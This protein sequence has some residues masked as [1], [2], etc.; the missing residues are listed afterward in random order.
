MAQALFILTCFLGIVF[1]YFSAKNINNHERL[2]VSVVTIFLATLFGS[3]FLTRI[4]QFGLLLLSSILVI[5]IAIVALKSRFAYHNQNKNNN[6]NFILYAI[7]L[8]IFVF[9]AIYPTYYLLGGRDPGLYFIYSVHIANTGGLNLD[10]P[11]LRELYQNFGDAI[12]LGYPGIYSGFNRGLSEDPANLIPQ[13]MHLFPAFGAIAHKIAGIEGVVRANAVI[14]IIALWSFFTVTRRLTGFYTALIA[15]LALGLNAAFIW[16]ARITL[17]ET[18]SIALLFSGIY[19]LIVSYDRNSTNWAMLGG[20][21][22]GLSVLNRLDASLNVLLI[23]G[24]LLLSAYNHKHFKTIALPATISYLIGSSIG[25]LDGLI[26]TFPYMHDLWRGGSLSKLVYLNYFLPLIGISIYLTSKLSFLSHERRKIL[27]FLGLKFAVFSLIVWSVFAFFIWH[28]IQEGFNARSINELAWYTTP[29][30]FI[31][32]IY[33]IRI[34][35]NDTESSHIILPLIVT[36]LATFI[37][38]TWKP[39]ITPDHIWA[40][41]RWVTHAIPFIILFS[42]IGLKHIFTSKIKTPIKYSIITIVCVFYLF[43]SLWMS[44]PFVFKSIYKQSSYDYKHLSADLNN[45]YAS[46]FTR[47]GQLA[48]ILTYIYGHKTILLTNAGLEI[49]HSGQFEN[50][51]FIGVD[52]FMPGEHLGSHS[53]C[54]NYLEKLRGARPRQLYRRCYNANIGIVQDDLKTSIRAYPTNPRFGSR[55]GSFDS[56]TQS[57]SST[58]KR[59]FLLFGP[60]IKLNPGK[61]KVTWLVHSTE[62]TKN[63]IGFVDIVSNKGSNVITRQDISNLSLKADSSVE[64][65]FLLTDAVDDLEFRFYVFD[66]IDLTISQVVLESIEE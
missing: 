19:F 53:I 18:L 51:P 62:E 27:F 61:Y 33:G 44:K 38:F 55:V 64:I 59:G 46:Y 37:L 48:S 16:N 65:E 47:N 6:K 9:Y 63:T 34:A 52:P 58:G 31:S 28:D 39:T 2:F 20:A 30:L 54:G 40:S 35:K 60:Y 12:R 43:N 3:L 7:L 50:I 56:K 22:L 8:S 36:G 1:F 21:I 57:V 4:G 45:S 49:M 32:F 29:V 5:L 25:F 10:L 42:A 23:F 17:T 14:A 13:F 15:M 24:I 41:R 66:N 11:I 26:H